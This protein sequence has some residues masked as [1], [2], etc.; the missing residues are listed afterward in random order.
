MNEMASKWQNDI[1]M[2]EWHSNDRMTFKWWNDTWMRFL[3]SDSNDMNDL[4]MNEMTSKWQNDIQM[5]EWHSN[6]GMIHEWGF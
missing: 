4:C 5:T 3:G 6:D 1:Q 2:T